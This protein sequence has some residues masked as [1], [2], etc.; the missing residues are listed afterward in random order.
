MNEKVRPIIT[1]IAV[2][3]ITAGFFIGKITSESYMTLMAVA[4]TWWF[5]TKDADK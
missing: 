4:V 3:G 1:V 2:L 5:K